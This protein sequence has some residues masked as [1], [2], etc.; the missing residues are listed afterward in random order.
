[1][2]KKNGSSVSGTREWA[3]QTINIDEGCKHDCRYCYARHIAEDRFHRVKRGEWGKPRIRENAVHK[4]RRKI[5]G[6]IMFPSSHDVC[7]ENLDRSMVV[8]DNLLSAGNDV[9]LVSKP[10]KTCIAAICDK[11]T[12]YKQQLRFRF[13]IGC[14]DDDLLKYWEPGA[15]DYQ[16]RMECLAL[17]HANGFSTSVSVEPMLDT[18]HIVEHVERLDPL[19]TDTIWLGKMNC[20]R[21]RVRIE[22]DVDRDAVQRIEAGQ[23]DERICEIYEA[24]KDNSKIRWKENIKKV[25]GLKLADKPGLDI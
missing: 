7:P 10:S 18:A 22:N 3:T 21:S 24:L 6:V 16:A 15:P 5:D 19:V 1:M 9:L 23:T 13:T 2:T 8:L 12:D 4:H 20:A 25:V 17:A 11:F 14:F